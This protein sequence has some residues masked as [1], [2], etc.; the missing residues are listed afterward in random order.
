MKKVWKDIPDYGGLYQVSNLSEV[1][2][3]KRNKELILKREV[4]KQGYLKVE[5]Y[6]NGKKKPFFVHRLVAQ[7]F[8]P[9]LNNL[10]QVNHKDGNKQNNNIENLEW[11]NN[12]QNQKHAYDNGLRKK[13]CGKNNWN[14]ISVLQFDIKGVLIKEWGSIKDASRGLKINDSDIS[15]CCKHKRKTAG[16]FKWEYK[17]EA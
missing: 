14:A 7:A 16:G 3:F 9:N 17:K 10:P 15:Y 4:N 5:L 8:I 2:S 12:S 13:Y 11:V 6:K 1:K